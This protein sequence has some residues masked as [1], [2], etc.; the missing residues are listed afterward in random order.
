[1]IATVQEVRILA[2]RSLRH[3]P[4]IPGEAF[5]GRLPL[6]LART[7]AGPARGYP[8]P[9]GGTIMVGPGRGSPPITHLSQSPYASGKIFAL[10]VET[11]QRAR[12][13]GAPPACT[14]ADKGADVAVAVVGSVSGLRS[15]EVRVGVPAT[16]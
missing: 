8:N 12:H 2:G 13:R 14:A 6:F 3:I 4:R 1:M 15:G 9:L 16:V 5:G 10:R 7:R 11:L